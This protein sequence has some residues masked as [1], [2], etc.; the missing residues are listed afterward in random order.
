[1]SQ[2]PRG[3]DSETPGAT[4]LTAL[5]EYSQ[6]ITHQQDHQDSAKPD[7]CAAASAPPAVAVVSAAAAENQ[8]Q[9]H[10]KND[11]HHFSSPSL[12]VTSNEFCGH[13]IAPRVFS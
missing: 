13:Q 6:Q 5:V 7:A 1:M 12:R 10:D 11:H 2:T 4:N 8:H 3:L 9:N